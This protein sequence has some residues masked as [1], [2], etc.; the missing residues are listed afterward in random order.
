MNELINELLTLL[1]CKNEIIYKCKDLSLKELFEYTDYLNSNIII[2]RKKICELA[3]YN[4]L[5]D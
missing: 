1:K 3:N 4:K 2:T 5:K